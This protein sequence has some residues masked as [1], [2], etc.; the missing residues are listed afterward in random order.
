MIEQMVLSMSQDEPNAKY[1]MI[2]WDNGT[3]LESKVSDDVWN[4]LQKVQ[5]ELELIG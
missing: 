3:Y 2:Y 5:D 4:A 1:V